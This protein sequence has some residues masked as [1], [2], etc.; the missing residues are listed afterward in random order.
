VYYEW[1]KSELKTGLRDMTGDGMA[2]DPHHC[3]G[4]FF[5]SGKGLKTFDWF[6]I[7]L[8][9]RRHLEFHRGQRSF[10][11]KYSTQK[12][13]LLRFWRQIDFEPG[14]FMLEGLSIKEQLRLRRVLGRLGY[15]L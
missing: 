10:E 13:M 12:E 7:P 4:N 6:V 5:E 15:E 14:L 3:L 2:V 11:K 9:R 1:F 8:S